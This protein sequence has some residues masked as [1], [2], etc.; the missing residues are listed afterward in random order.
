[1]LLD[2]YVMAGWGICHFPYLTN[3]VTNPF[4]YASLNSI[5]PYNHHTTSTVWASILYELY[6]NLLETLP[7]QLDLYSASPNHGKT[8]ALLLVVIGLK[9]QSCRPTFIMACNAIMQAKEL[10]TQDQNKCA[11]TGVH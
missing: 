3:Q 10:L 11:V 4:S 6:W 2:K 1:M 5:R 8:L 7:F 9:L